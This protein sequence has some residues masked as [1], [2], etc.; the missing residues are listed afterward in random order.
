V[1]DNTNNIRIGDYDFGD[2]GQTLT[3]VEAFDAMVAFLN[4]F[5]KRDGSNDDSIAWLL[6]SCSRDI[7]HDSGPNDPTM[8]SD[9]QKAIAAM[10]ASKAGK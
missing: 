2:H 8:W 6:S 9:W 7:W 10:K 3:D 5:W 1:N 4:D